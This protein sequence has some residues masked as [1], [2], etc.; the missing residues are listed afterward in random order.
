[1]PRRRYEARREFAAKTT[2]FP[3]RRKSAEQANKSAKINGTV[4]S[5]QTNLKVMKLL[6]FAELNFFLLFRTGTFPGK[7][8]HCFCCRPVVPKSTINVQ[9]FF[10]T[11]MHYNHNIAI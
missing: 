3:I 2:S 4:A 1:M 9:F 8:Q 11:K 10:I 5:P 7:V 6:R